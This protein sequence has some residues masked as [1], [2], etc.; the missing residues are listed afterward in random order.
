MFLVGNREGKRP[1]ARHRRRLEDNIGMNFSEI[2]SKTVNWVHLAQ[3]RNIWRSAVN[4]VMIIQV[5]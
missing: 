1:L 2:E 5:N 4:V 3:D